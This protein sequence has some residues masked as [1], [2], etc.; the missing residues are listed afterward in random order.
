VVVSHLVT[1]LTSAGPAA[2]AAVS[3][4]AVVSAWPAAPR[5]VMAAELLPER[6]LAG[7]PE[8]L[9]EL[10]TAV[11]DPIEAS[12]Q[13]QTLA[14]YLEQAG[15]LEECARRMFVHVNTVR[16]RLGQVSALT[17]LNPTDPRGSFVLRVALIAGR[18]RSDL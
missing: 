14:C 15:S 16:Y 18:L 7:D 1:D 2:R 13:L 8:A 6:A 10:V 5:P 12:G 11:H 9:T 3:G 17:G 4:L